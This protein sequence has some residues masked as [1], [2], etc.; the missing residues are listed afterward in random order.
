MPEYFESNFRLLKE[1]FPSVAEFAISMRDKTFSIFK[2]KD[3]GMVYAVKGQDGQWQPISNPVNPI[4]CAQR[5][6][7]QMSGRLSAGMSPAIIVGLA[8]G[9]ALDTVFKLFE[10]QASEFSPFRHIYVLVDSPLCLCAWLTVADRSKMLSHPEIEFQEKA[11]A[12]VDS[13]EKDLRRSHLFI[14]ISELPPQLVNMLIEPLANLYLKRE[15]EAETWSRE[16]ETYYGTISDAELS[17]IIKGGGGHKPRLMMPTHTSSTVIQFSTRDTCELFESEGWETRIIK[18]ERDLPPW[19]LIKAIHEFKPDLFIFIDHLRTEDA[20]GKLY[21]K[22]MLFATWVQDSLPAINSKKSAEE[23][24]KAVEGRNRD[25]LIGYVDQVAPYGYKPDRLFQMPMVVNTKI[26]HPVELSKGDRETYSC[27]VCFASNRSDPTEKATSDA[28]LPALATQGFKL[29]TL[30]E[31]HDALWSDY[32]SGRSYIGYDSLKKRLLQIASFNNIFETLEANAQD[33]VIQRVFWLLNDL[34]YRHVVIE[35]LAEYAQTHPA[36]KLKLYGRGW[37]THPCFR[38]YAAGVAEH[39]SALNKAYNA[40]RHCLHLN[41]MEGQHQRIL[42]I[43]A[44]GSSPLTRYSPSQF[45]SR[46]LEMAFA[47]IAKVSASHT[48][49]FMESSSIF[50]ADEGSAFAS[51]VFHSMLET[52]PGLPLEEKVTELLGQLATHIGNVPYYTSPKFLNMRFDKKEELLAIVG[53]Q[54]PSSSE[55]SP[56]PAPNGAARINCALLDHLERRCLR[57]FPREW[58][59]NGLV[60]LVTEI[61]AYAMSF[62]RVKELVEPDAAELDELAAAYAK[63]S[64]KGLQLTCATSALLRGQERLSAAKDEIISILD[65]GYAMEG[66]ELCAAIHLLKRAGLT[67]AKSEESIVRWATATKDLELADKAISP[68]LSMGETKLHEMARI[69]ISSRKS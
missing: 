40:A 55:E 62:K 11:Q 45:I 52:S 64:I 65:S 14:P 4:E 42:E 59:S 2:S 1:R 33:Y 53:T 54:L 44:S 48:A 60:K 46:K 67:S 32:R 31:V 49:N 24:N 22:D 9:Y 61:S 56:W 41:A 20:D 23:W 16:N 30:K 25:L 27:D 51:Q 35:W 5:S 17:N 29:E 3:G 26:F 57:T 66:A 15:S 58:N 63:L 10:R 47:K 38:K 69:I 36:F 21:P 19:H 8:P 34:I 18:I 12:I 28:L 37:K 43:L 7:D 13:C 50:T 39:G 68:L 6:L